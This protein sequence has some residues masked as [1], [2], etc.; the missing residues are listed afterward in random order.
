MENIKSLKNF[1]KSED[2][3]L[4]QFEYITT[5]LDSMKPAS[6]S[7]FVLLPLARTK[8]WHYS[9]F[10]FQ[11]YE[12]SLKKIMQFFEG[13]VVLFN[14]KRWRNI[15]AEYVLSNIPCKLLVAKNRLMKRLMMDPWKDFNSTL[16]A[17][18]VL[19]LN[20][21]QILGRAK[22]FCNILGPAKVFC[23]KLCVELKS[24]LA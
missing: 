22:V 10:P 17:D 19:S 12:P 24:R 3:E 11:N 21:A 9:V 13:L 6:L 8:F 15:H 2:K 7:V 20:P 18:I 5:I 23:E 1:V 4:L 16:F 14:R